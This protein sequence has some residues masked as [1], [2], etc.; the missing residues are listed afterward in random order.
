[1]TSLQKC[2]LQIKPSKIVKGQGLCRLVAES[3]DSKENEEGWEN[4]EKKFEKEVC[5]I[6]SS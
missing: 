5:Y 2:D 1:M 4:E 6:P 3:N